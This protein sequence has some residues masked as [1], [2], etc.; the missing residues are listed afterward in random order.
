MPVG[1]AA[2]P[3]DVTEPFDAARVRRLRAAIAAGTYRVDAAAVAAGLLR[4]ERLLAR[5][6]RRA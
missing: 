2:W 3:E 4:V 1:R 6:P 5:S